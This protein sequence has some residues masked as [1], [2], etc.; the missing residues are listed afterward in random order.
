MADFQIGNAFVKANR[1][2]VRGYALSNATRLFATRN[3]VTGLITLPTL[4]NSGSY[5]NFQGVT[6]ASFQVNDNN[7]EFR[8][9]GD[10]GWSDSVITGSSV[11]SSVTAYFQKD[12]DA[13]ATSLITGT[14][15]GTIT[16]GSGYTNG[17]YSNVPLTTSGSG[18]GATAN[19]TVSGG[20]VTAV[21]IVNGGSGYANADT[22]SAS[23]TNLGGAGTSFSLTVAAARLS[24]G[25]IFLGGYDEAFAMIE[26]ARYDKSFEIYFE[27]LK[28]LGQLNDGSAD[29]AKYAYDFAGFNGCIM[30]YNESNSAENLVEVSFDVMS[31]GRPVFGRYL[32]STQLSV[33][34]VQ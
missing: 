13:N 16:G 33:S 23:N 24:A 1:T 20:A 29:A 8:L 34:S 17:S 22:L 27:F 12:I 5:V 19:I 26:R 25:P 21:V 3:G 11:Q 28:E 18:T 6:Q 10:D 32:S 7:Q 31:R 9:L 14:W 15:G 2:V 4:P 30:N